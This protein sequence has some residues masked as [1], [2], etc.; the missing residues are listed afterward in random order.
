MKIFAFAL[1]FG[2]PFF[3]SALGDPLPPQTI[4]NNINSTIAPGVTGG[5]TANQANPVFQ[6]FTPFTNMWYDTNTG[7]VKIY[8][9]SAWVPGGF[10]TGSTSGNTKNFLTTSGAL[11][12]GDCPKFDIYQNA[13]DSGSTCILNPSIPSLHEGLG[14]T[15]TLTSQF[16]THGDFI[17]DLSGDASLY[18][19]L[20]VTGTPTQG[21]IPSVT[22]T[23]A[24]IPY[25]VTYTVPSGATN[26][27]I[28]IGICN[29][30]AANTSLVSALSNFYDVYGI[31]YAPFETG[32]V[33]QTSANTVSFD[34]PWGTSNSLVA[35]SSAHT[36]L[37]IVSGLT[38]TGTPKMDG[39][40][41]L[42][43]SRSYPA[44][45]SLNSGDL[46]PY[47][48]FQAFNTSIG[49]MQ[50]GYIDTQ[51]TSPT[52]TKV[53]IGSYGSNGASDKL[54]IGN[55]VFV[56]GPTDSCLGDIGTGILTSCVMESRGFILNSAT[57]TVSG[58][59]QAALF[60]NG[61]GQM[62]MTNAASNF[63]FN[64]HTG[65]TNV[66]TIN[67]SNSQLDYYG[68]TQFHSFTNLLGAVSIPSLPAKGSFTGG[69]V[70]VST[71]GVLYTVSSGSA[72]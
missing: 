60:I 56:T 72:C 45:Y 22:W 57:G 30:I 5:I 39:G 64:N 35:N 46:G 1:I 36:T 34:Q 29:A 69:G 71:T 6:Y 18:T 8:N 12:N 68:G 31:G 2:V 63:Y 37:S 42:Q 55:G 24:G 25:T 19:S 48:N 50:M 21:E 4:I 13:I 54:S 44:G 33:N 65:V 17:W 52:T 61:S 47:L 16:E 20:I 27:T 3:S 23:V 11:T 15:L 26:S 7:L 67:D 10:L 32:C 14:G 9:G 58:A 53:N 43:A 51:F 66:Y 70:C 59:P 62:E 38:G 40:P 41:V 49:E 28:A